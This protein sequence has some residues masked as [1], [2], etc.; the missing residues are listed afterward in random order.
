MAAICKSCRKNINNFC[1]VSG[2][3]INRT[4]TKCKKFKIAYEQTQLFNAVGSSGD[5]NRKN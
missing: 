3:P 1:K 4:R 2:E 5:M